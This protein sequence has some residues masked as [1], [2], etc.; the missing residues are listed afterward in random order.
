MSDNKQEGAVRFEKER[1]IRSERF[2]E[3]A[4]LLGVLLTDGE[5]YTAEEAEKAIEK[6]ME[7]KVI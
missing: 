7:G 4:D 6:Y 5:A 2:A 3:R 1:L